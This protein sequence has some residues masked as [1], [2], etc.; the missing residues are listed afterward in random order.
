[1]A[2]PPGWLLLPPGLSLPSV[3]L[4]MSKEASSIAF[5]GIVRSTS[6]DITSNGELYLHLICNVMTD[7]MQTIRPERS[8]WNNRLISGRAI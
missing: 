8:A 2:R 3:F 6:A 7:A 1:M 5:D 4:Y